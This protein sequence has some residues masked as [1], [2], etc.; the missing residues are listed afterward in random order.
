MIGKEDVGLGGYKGAEPGQPSALR[1][2]PLKSLRACSAGGYQ[3]DTLG[4]AGSP[5]GRTNLAALEGTSGHPPFVP[6][7]FL[8]ASQRRHVRLGGPGDCAGRPAG[9]LA[10]PGRYVPSGWLLPSAFLLR[11]RALSR[12][13]PTGQVG[14]ERQAATILPLFP[15]MSSLYTPC[16]V[17]AFFSPPIS[18]F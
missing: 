9:H 2:L 7:A 4:S 18:W 12:S 8:R 11:P 15:Y 14:K 1:I 16:A 3:E 17:V 10:S 13:L 5:T 6:S